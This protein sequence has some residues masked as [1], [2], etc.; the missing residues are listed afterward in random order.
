MRGTIKYLA[1]F[2][3]GVFCAGTAQP[4]FLSHTYRIDADDQKSA[5][6][7]ATFPDSVTLL[8]PIFTNAEQF[9]SIVEVSYGAHYVCT[10]RLLDTVA[11]GTVYIGK[12]KLQQDTI[13]SHNIMNHPGVT[14]YQIVNTYGC[15]YVRF[16][17]EMVN[18]P[19]LLPPR[20][21]SGYGHQTDFRIAVDCVALAIYGKRRQGYNVPYCSPWRIGNY[22]RETCDIETGTVIFFGFHVAVVYEDRGNTGE[23]DRDDLIIHAYKDK[24][25]IVRFGDTDLVNEKYITYRWKKN[26][27]RF[28]NR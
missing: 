12:Q 7:L 22:L 23:L 15:G 27:P 18:V 26:L 20:Y 28:S 10:Q 4:D 17:E 6:V 2:V 21:I 11:L 16:L 24:A 8:T 25:E 14:V 19:F 3:A 5:A 9:D 13:Q 1:F